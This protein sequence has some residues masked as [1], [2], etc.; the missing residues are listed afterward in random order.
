[1]NLLLDKNLG[2]LDPFLANQ[3]AGRG[4]LFLFFQGLAGTFL[5]RLIFSRGELGEKVFEDIGC[6]NLNGINAG[7]LFRLALVVALALADKDALEAYLA[8]MLEPSLINLLKEELRSE[9]E[10]LSADAD[11]YTD[12]LGLLVD[13]LDLIV[14]LLSKVALH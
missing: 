11:Q 13:P 1:M 6:D 10:L 3:L 8:Q 4:M 14:S 12:L 5:G 7:I 2:S 9:L